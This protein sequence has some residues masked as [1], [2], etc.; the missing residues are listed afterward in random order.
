MRSG[1]NASHR[2]KVLYLCLS[3]MKADLSTAPTAYV[4]ASAP[5]AIHINEPTKG[6][7]PDLLCCEI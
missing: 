6:D 5:E 1:I 7:R 3:L 4:A 2:Q